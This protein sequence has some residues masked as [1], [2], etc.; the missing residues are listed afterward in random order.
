MI[1]QF[2]SAAKQS[3][4]VQSTH[5]DDTER[6][7]SKQQRTGKTRLR[8]LSTHRDDEKRTRRLFNRTRSKRNTVDVTAFSDSETWD[9]YNKTL[10]GSPGIERRFA[11]WGARVIDDDATPV[12]FSPRPPDSE[13]R[14]RTNRVALHH[15]IHVHT[16]RL[17]LA[18]SAANG[19]IRSADQS[20]EI[21]IRVIPR[22]QR[23]DSRTDTRT[24]TQKKTVRKL[25]IWA[26]ELQMQPWRSSVVQGNADP[27]KNSTVTS[28]ALI[29]AP[30]LKAQDSKSW[31]HV[32]LN[33]RVC[34]PV[35]N[36]KGCQDK[37]DMPAYITSALDNSRS[38]VLHCQQK[39]WSCIPSPEL[40]NGTKSVRA[41][42]CACVCACVW[43]PVCV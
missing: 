29:Q 14:L 23:Q 28:S 41:C 26:W 36:W 32:L 40:L 13:L 30:D 37:V 11:R 19:C 31:H 5:T 6:W 24:H 43:L 2:H 27:L 33:R 35:W 15:M 7:P 18:S 21:S 38:T 34:G 16:R 22:P 10:C 20:G 3:K 39:Q 42:A 12:D 4:R 9:T 1:C 25:I 17:R 8:V